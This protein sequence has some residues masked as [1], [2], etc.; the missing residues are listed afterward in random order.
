MPAA[1]CE[2][3]GTAWFWFPVK[4]TPELLLTFLLD[5]NRYL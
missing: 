3:L 2:L 1:R 5:R 4:C